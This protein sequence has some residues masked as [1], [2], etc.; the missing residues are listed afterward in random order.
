MYAGETVRWLVCA[1]LA[2]ANPVT[3]QHSARQWLDDMS[4]ALQNLNYDGT[5]VFLHDDHLE[6]MRIIHRSDDAGQRERLVS[7]TGSAR[8]VLRDDRTVTCILPDNKSVMVGKSRLSQPF[9]QLPADLDSISRYYRLEDVGDDRMV[10][11]MARVIAITPRDAFRYGYRFWIDKDTAMLLKSDLTGVDGGAIE[12]LMFTALSIGPDIPEQDLQPAMSGDDYEW[13]NQMAGENQEEQPPAVPG[14]EV[15]RLPDGFGLTNYRVR[16][17]RVGRGMAEHMVFSD[18]LA[19][20]SVYIEDAARVSNPLSG[21]S[22]MG[23]MNAYGTVVDKFQVT[24][25]GEVPPATVEMM[26]TSLSRN[27]AQ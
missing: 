17:M 26:A 15:E 23:A 8:E 22:G 2:V 27:T 20:V 16:P 10:G 4:G 13:S 5:F 25:V 12:Q 1:L 14:W 3:A 6:T 11:R 9:P 19:T 24:V 7:M 21:P 18:G